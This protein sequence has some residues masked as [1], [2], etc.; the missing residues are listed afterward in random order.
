MSDYFLHIS[1]LLQ[2]SLSFTLRVTNFRWLPKFSRLTL[3]CLMMMNSQPWNCSLLFQ[4]YTRSPSSKYRLAS[5][6]GLGVHSP[7]KHLLRS[8]FTA[9][10]GFLA[11]HIQKHSNTLCRLHSEEILIRNCPTP[12]SSYRAILLI[13]PDIILHCQDDTLNKTKKFEFWWYP[14]INAYPLH[15]SPVL[16]LDIQ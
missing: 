10:Q 6:C 8:T 15:N 16:S 13:S 2:L 4:E 5:T 14:L 3:F 12:L 11:L 9:N 7:L 1:K